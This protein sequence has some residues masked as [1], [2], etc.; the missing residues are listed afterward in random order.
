MFFIKQL[1]LSPLAILAGTAAH[2]IVGMLWYSPLLFGNVWMR[3]VKIDK[4]KISMHSGHLIGAALIG[5]TISLFMAHMIDMQG[6]TCCL[7]SIPFALLLWLG[8]VATTHFSNVIWQ[9]KCMA[10]YLIEAGYWA[11]N[12]SIISCVVTKL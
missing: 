8:L 6:F 10:A 7:D 5:L 2:M 3:S 11:A 9:G 12:L 4:K 1:A